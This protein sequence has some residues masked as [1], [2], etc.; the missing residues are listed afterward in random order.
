M[1]STRFF[2]LSRARIISIYRTQKCCKNAK[3]PDFLCS[4]LALYYF[5]RKI[6]Q[7]RTMKKIIICLF[8]VLAL[9]PRAFAQS[10]EKKFALVGVGFY[11]LENLFDTLHDEGKNDYEYLP[12][13][14]QHWGT[15][16]YTSKVKNMAR[17]L[18]ELC[19]DRLKSG[20]AVIGVSEVENKNVLEDLCAQ[21][22][23]AERGMK[24]VHYEGPDRRGIDCAF[25]YNPRLFKLEKSF[26]VPF[27]YLDKNQPDV[28]LGF[29]VDENK[30]VVPY[31]NF[32]R[33][34]TTY[35]TRGF[36]VMSGTILGEK[37]HFIVNHWPS[38]GATSPAR[39]RAGYQVRCLKDALVQQDP[40]CKVVIMGDMNDDP[41]NKSMTE[42][43]GCY[44]KEKDV[45]TASDLYNPW[46]DMLYKVGQG[47]L[48]YDGKW[49]LFDQIVFTGNLLGTDR[50]TF[51]FYQS[52]VYNP[53]YLITDEGQFK[54][55]PRRTHAKGIWVNGYSD[56][57]PTYIY[58]IKELK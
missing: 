6:N 18:G 36:L 9:T 2:A 14:V 5:W 23:L 31:T 12:G 27:Y 43:L 11:N 54:G 3:M 40:G 22:V 52:R 19:T 33:G 57:L 48:L 39:E 20:A 16:K 28:D 38:R 7:T 51:K 42:A 55:I 24:Y 41:N 10:G 30:Q 26:L 13:G 21:P 37:F 8:A 56:H 4:S 32:M 35:A 47:T 49:N 58:L 53:D 44:H 46:W 17:V 34:D 1:I 29:Y 50:S 45:K 15:M 25:L